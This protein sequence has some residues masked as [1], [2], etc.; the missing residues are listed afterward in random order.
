MWF[1]PLA[2]AALSCGFAL[3][4]LRDLIARPRPHVAAWMGAL[5]MF[6][7]A[8]AAAAV[9]LAFGWSSPAF[10][11]YYLFGAIV[12]VPVLALGTVYLF[13]PRR[14]AHVIAVGVGL[15]CLAAAG[16]VG[17]A[18][19]S[20][21]G[22]ATDGIPSA[23]EVVGGGVRTWSRYASFSGFFVVVA[24]ALWSAWRLA[25]TPEPSAKRLAY[26]NILIATGTFIVAVASGFARYGRGAVLA[27]GLAAG[28]AVMFSGFLQ[29][30]GRP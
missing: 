29:A 7:L 10:R 24:G 22:L 12:N 27:V 11:I 19:L 3:V 5:A 21:A 13:L 26:G 30:R 17:S 14:P 1:F 16:V 20:A 18:E 8:S 9:G 28:V 4:L 15:A 25:R 23:R 6:S 2:A